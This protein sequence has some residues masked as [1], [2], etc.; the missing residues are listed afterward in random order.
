MRSAAVLVALGLLLSGLA[1]GQPATAAPPNEQRALMTGWNV[2]AMPRVCTNDGT[3]T[4]INCVNVPITDAQ[5]DGTSTAEAGDFNN[6]GIADVVIGNQNG[7]LS[8]CLQDNTG[9]FTC[10]ANGAIG[11][12]RGIAVADFNNDGNQDLVGAIETGTLM[13]VCLGDGTGGFTC[14]RVAA[15]NGGRAIEAFDV[16]NDGDMDMIYAAFPGPSAVCTNDGSGTFTCGTTVGAGNNLGVDTGDFNGDGNRDF[17]L[18]GAGTADEHVCLGNGTVTFTCSVFNAGGYHSQVSVGDIDNDGDDDAV[19]GGDGTSTLSCLGDGAG[20]FTCGTVAAAPANVGSVD[21]GD[22]DSDGTLDVLFGSVGGVVNQSCIGDGFG[23]YTCSGIDAPNIWN[24]QGVLILDPL[25]P[26]PDGDVDGVPDASDNCPA[27]ANP[28]QIDTDGDLSGDACDTDDD[29]DGLSD[30]DE[31]GVHGTD[32]LLVDTDTDTLSDFDEVTTWLT[33]PLLVDTDTDTLSDADEI[34]IHGTNPLLFDTDGDSWDDAY[35]LA[36]GG[37]PLAPALPQAILLPTPADITFDVGSFNVSPSAGSGNPVLLA[38]T[39]PCTASGYTVTATGVGGCDLA[40]DEPGDVNWQAAPT[41]NL[42]VMITPGV[43]AITHAPIPPAVFGDAPVTLSAAASSGLPVAITATG[44]CT[45][46]GVTLSIDG[47]G[48]CEVSFD[49]P[50]DV[51]WSGAA[52]V[53][54]TVGIGQA[55]QT[56]TV[57][58]PT[59]MTFG[60]GA[61]NLSAIATSNLPVAITATGP[62]AV[63][64]TTVT[65]TGT[66]TCTLSYDQP[67]DVDWSA[68]P[69]EVASFLIEPA[70]QVIT[71]DPIADRFFDEGPVTISPA[72]S[73]GLAVSITTSGACTA[74]G[75]TIT[76][77][78]AGVCEV[79]TTQDGNADWL[80]AS[81]F[82]DTFDIAPGRQTIDFD[83]PDAVVFGDEPVAV[84]PIASS[85]LP[86][87]LV[88]DGPCAQA[89][90]TVS[91]DAAGECTI[92]ASQPGN[93]DWAPAAAIERTL[94]INRAPQAVTAT[95]VVNRRFDDAPQP[96][97]F[98]AS[99]GLT[100]TVIVTG[101]CGFNLGTIEATGVGTC[102]VQVA[103]AGDGNWLPATPIDQSFTITPGQAVL[104]VEVS[105]V[106]LSDAAQPAAVTVEPAGLDGVEIRYDGDPAVPTEPGD[107]ELTVALNNPDWVADPITETFTVLEPPV[108]DDELGDQVRFISMSVQDVIDDGLPEP[109]PDGGATILT[110][111]GLTPGSAA[112]LKGGGATVT[113]IADAK[114]IAV[115]DIAAAFDLANSTLTIVDILGPKTV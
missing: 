9:N 75:S 103:Q 16:D 43:Q 28:A 40:F 8:T 101:P 48:T 45:V 13:D 97:T 32:P 7:T 87:A 65:A 54:T 12:H 26:P 42:T 66:G 52:T 60:G 11:R 107:Y 38:V 92:T 63:A 36:N 78:G 17:I 25:G 83:P 104:Q 74:T 71:P 39:G 5:P 112:S 34:N 46:T 77:T 58:P 21:L 35:E 115:L 84:N 81:P 50:G 109:D 51:D 86:V 27:V 100:P 47:A 19:I 89:A 108:V 37:D 41:V 56:I 61:Q 79:T 90:N 44:P 15:P 80:A 114:A 106:G 99:S 91:H 23:D 53:T 70:P 93:D 88:V 73:S 29:D 10:T 96:F 31:T 105:V 82:V 76:P 6:D 110:L 68:A 22:I 67:G 24:T 72:A 98:S 59:A 3:G 95:T 111:S 2:G 1:T 113:A 30:V 18:A 57:T 20:G 33:D 49:Q 69:T 4:W 94:V 102:D 55:A 64:G 62:C 14:N 85:G